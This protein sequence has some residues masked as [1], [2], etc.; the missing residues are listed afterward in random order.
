MVEV[1][2]LSSMDAL[3]A[4]TS[5]AARMLRINAGF[6]REGSL[7]DIVV[8]NGN[9]IENIK[10]ISKIINVIKDGRSMAEKGSLIT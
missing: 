8:I 2:G 4:A 10:D 1:G 9:P 7:A 3:R 6:V 5:N